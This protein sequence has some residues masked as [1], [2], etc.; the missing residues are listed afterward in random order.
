MNCFRAIVRCY[1]FTMEPPTR[2][3]R[4]RSSPASRQLVNI[5]QTYPR[6]PVTRKNSGVVSGL[7]CCEDCR[8]QVVGRCFSGRQNLRL[9][10]VFPVMF[11][12]TFPLPST[13]VTAGSA[14]APRRPKFCARVGPRPRTTTSVC[15]CS[16]V[17]KAGN[18]H[19]LVNANKTCESRHW[20][21]RRNPRHRCLYRTL[22]PARRR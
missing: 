1:C 17:N 11:R 4:G 6:P 21:A 16:L 15:R 13:R 9:L 14:R 3:R 19:V 12:T 5:R 18:H 20:L 8:L 22:P 7:D 10:R 2:R